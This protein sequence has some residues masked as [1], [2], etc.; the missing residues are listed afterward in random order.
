M[1]YPRHSTSNFSVLIKLLALWHQNT[2]KQ[3]KTWNEGMLLTLKIHTRIHT[4]IQ[5]DITVFSPFLLFVLFCYQ[6]L[7]SEHDKF[8]HLSWIKHTHTQKHLMSHSF[9]NLGSLNATCYSYKFWRGILH[10]WLLTFYATCLCIWVK[11]VKG[12]LISFGKTIHLSFRLLKVNPS[13]DL[14]KTKQ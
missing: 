1:K 14:Q 7:S 4:P 6:K 13:P 9:H 11:V 5:E 2:H 12:S 10:S 3:S 8:A